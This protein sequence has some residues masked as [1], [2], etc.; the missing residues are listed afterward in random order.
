MRGSPLIVYR[1]L[2]RLNCGCTTGLTKCAEW[3]DVVSESEYGGGSAIDL[4]RI[5]EMGLRIA[6][7]GVNEVRELGRVA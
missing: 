5:F 6:L 4:L 1:R 7:L 2:G 3:N